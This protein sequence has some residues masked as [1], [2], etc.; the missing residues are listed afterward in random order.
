MSDALDNGL[1]RKLSDSEE[2][3]KEVDAIEAD[4]AALKVAYEQY[5]LGAERMPPTKQHADLKK[6]VQ[7]LKGAFTRQT[8]MKFRV[9]GVHSKFLS[10][11]RLW[12]RTLQEMESGTYK[13][14]VFKA[15]L[16]Q[17]KKAAPAAAQAG[18]AGPTGAPPPPGTLSD[19]RL[20]AVYEAYVLAKQRCQEDTSK[21]SFETLAANLR[22][23]V[24]E[25][26]K[27]HKANGVDFK[28]VIKDGK[29]ILRAVPK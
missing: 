23:Q 7:R 5:F 21:L 27:K 3:G 17:Q 10:Y 19:S 4:I 2:V 26:M 29:A 15:K 8:A 11:E 20:R 1:N 22:K 12:A 13:R 6:R 16:H 24:P 25:L 9:Q 28:I 14:D 18:A